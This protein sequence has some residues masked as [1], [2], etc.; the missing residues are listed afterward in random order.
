M[1]TAK[2][3]MRSEILDEKTCPICKNQLDGIVLPADD[4][5]WNVVYGLPAHRNCR[6]VLVPIFE[7]IDPVLSS[8]PDD[9]LPE[10]VFHS[11]LTRMLP[12]QQA[13]EEAVDIEEL[14]GVLGGAEW[15]VGR[16]FTE[17]DI[18]NIIDPLDLLRLIYRE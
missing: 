2:M 11:Y 13:L 17:E 4:P 9:E 5:R 1:I 14:R 3:I 12:L 15:V 16:E 10:F 8:T 7:G 6:Y 18:R